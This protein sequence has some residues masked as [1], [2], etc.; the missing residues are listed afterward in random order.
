M[1]EKTQFRIMRGKKDQKYWVQVREAY[2]ASDFYQLPEFKL[3]FFGLVRVRT[4]TRTEESKRREYRYYGL[5]RY[6][7]DGKEGSLCYGTSDHWS[8]QREFFETIEDAQAA[9][10]EQFAYEMID[11]TYEGEWQP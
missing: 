1:T 11:N 2:F 8:F 7:V 3:R 9:I 5:G 4:G 6:V 10:D